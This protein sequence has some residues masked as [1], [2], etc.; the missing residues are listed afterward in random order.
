TAAV[1]EVTNTLGAVAALESAPIF[2]R[3]FHEVFALRRDAGEVML[4]IAA[5]QRDAIAHF[6]RNLSYAPA[7]HTPYTLHPAIFQEPLRRAR[8]LGQRSSLHLCEHPA[9][10]AFLADGSGAFAEFLRAR[11]STPPDWSPPGLDPIR[12][13]HEQGA[14]ARDVLCVHLADARPD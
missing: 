5:Q 12:Y 3:I 13:A 10:R 2:G 9:E 4:G 6:P 8:A 1:G 7:P 14:L 11:N